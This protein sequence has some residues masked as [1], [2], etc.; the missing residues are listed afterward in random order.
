MT[1]QPLRV[2]G[3]ERLDP[4]WIQEEERQRAEQEGLQAE[5]AR[6]GT[7]APAAP[8]PATET[9]NRGAARLT[10]TIASRL[11]PVLPSSGAASTPPASA[12]QAPAAPVFTSSA[13]AAPASPTYSTGNAWVDSLRPTAE[14]YGQQLGGIPPEI[15]IAMNASESNWGAAPTLF[16]IK[17]KSP[18][19]KS[20]S[21]ATWESVN[22][23]RVDINDEFA[24]YDSPD[25]AYQHFISFL[26]DNP[27]YADAVKKAKAGDY[28]GFV[29]GLN[30]AGYATDPKWADL[31]LG[32]ASDI[33][34][35]RVPR[36]DA[37]A[38]GATSTAE[39]EKVNRRG[40]MARLGVAA[41][42]R[43]QEDQQQEQPRG[44]LGTIKRAAGDV[45]KAATVEIPG[46]KQVQDVVGRIGE[47]NPVG[48]L[49]ATDPLK[50]LDV[51]LVPLNLAGKGLEAAGVS[52]PLDNVSVR[53]AVVSNLP[54]GEFLNVLRGLGQDAQREIAESAIPVKVWEAALMAVPE[55]AKVPGGIRAARSL[56]QNI[57]TEE[58]ALAV[59]P[60][61]RRA[62]TEVPAF[63]PEARQVAETAGRVITPA[64]VG[65]TA[66][67]GIQL[68]GG[69]AETLPRVERAAWDV[70]DLGDTGIKAA[71]SAKQEAT[72]EPGALFGDTGSIQRKVV[73]AINPSV[74]MPREVHVAN[75]AR[76]AV[77]STT[78][79]QFAND[80]IRAY[81]ALEAAFNAN[82]PAYLGDA[83]RPLANTWVDFA[84]NPRL[85]EAGDALQAAKENL[86]AVQNRIISTVRSE[87]GVDVK[88]FQGADPDSVYIP[89]LQSRESMDK[90]VESTTRSLSSR[91]SVTKERAYDSLSDRMARDPKF[92]PELDAAVLADTHSSSLAQMAANN[93]FKAGVGGM[94]KVD[95]INELHPGLRGALIDARDMVT[96]LRGRIQ[97]AMRQAGENAAAGNLAESQ[98]NAINRR[99]EPLEARVESLGEEYGPEMAGLTSRIREMRTQLAQ[100]GSRSAFKASR[101]IG[102][103]ARAQ[104]LRRELD[105]AQRQV[106]YLAKAY[107]TAS[108]GDYALNPSTYRYHLPEVDQAIRSVGKTG[109]D[110]AF[111]DGLISTANTSRAAALGPDFSP[112]TIQG[113]LGFFSHPEIAFTDAGGLVK[114][115][116]QSPEA[117]RNALDPDLVRRFEFASNRTLGSLSEDFV[118]NRGIEL[119]GQ[120]LKKFNDALQ[121]VVDYG[122]IKAFEHDSELLQKL[123]AVS[124][125]AADHE[126]ANFISKAIPRLNNRETGRSAQR[127]KLEGLLPTSRSF[128]VAPALVAKDFLSGIAK[129]GTGGQ[130]LGRE[131]LALVRGTTA[132]GT[133]MSISIASALAFAEANGKNPTEAVKE[134]LDPNSSR[135]ASIIVGDEGSFSL[136]GPFR[137]AFLGLFRTV[138]PLAPGGDP[139][140]DAVNSPLR[141][142][143]NTLQP[144]I[145]T[146]VDVAMNR[147]WR[148][149]VIREGDSLAQLQQVVE[150]YAKNAN[151]LAGG[152]IEGMEE[153]GIS[154]ALTQIGAGLGGVNY[155]DRSPAELRNRARAD[156]TGEMFPGRKYEDLLTSEQAQVDADPRVARAIGDA[157]NYYGS[158]EYTVNRDR[159]LQ[160]LATEQETIEG[161][162]QRGE[163]SKPLPDLMRDLKSRRFQTLQDLKDD[164]AD[165]FKKLPDR[166]H[167]ESL[168]GFYAIE[169]KN[170]DGT[171]NWDKTI[172]AREDFIASL[173]DEEQAWVN[174]FLGFQQTKKSAIE[175]EYTAYNDRREQLG[176]F[177]PDADTKAL[178]RANPDIDF[179]TWRF[180]GGVQ[181]K[182]KNPD[183]VLQ[184]KEA[185]DKALAAN[186]PGRQV[187]LDGLSR[188]INE[189]QQTLAAWQQVGARLDKYLSGAQVERY[190]E[191]VAQQ[192]YQKPFKELTDNQQSSIAAY[193]QTEVRKSS[194]ELDAWLAWFG[195]YSVIQSFAA[196]SVLREIRNTYG[197]EP[198]GNDGPIRY[199]DNAR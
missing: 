55:I 65:D 101:E 161:A 103:E 36:S 2:P 167:Q 12:A 34:G 108:T 62:I 71:L 73:G 31:I 119:P 175:Q 35:G 117:L 77:L 17:G 26:N 130:L 83:S 95:V 60:A 49:A 75:Q 184:S 18:S 147:D 82:P 19:G 109:F 89:H 134:V 58:E 37:R 100:L 145:G 59:I 42:I 152:A 90:A 27:R 190:R 162:W 116:F 160:N 153:G 97:T 16:G 1:L 87:Y 43:A 46:A 111:I 24:V 177:A 137:R 157:K 69:A 53:D 85:Y 45:A 72:L 140:R 11:A 67:L 38:L 120:P 9:I 106:D 6:R 48:P 93:T 105:E 171:M 13:Q 70:P 131:K 4:A 188:P 199:A 176:Y 193:I 25:E 168:D 10:G 123:G 133:I 88:P 91:G 196:G 179:D 125:N 92:V 94:T 78:R 114:A 195:K 127:V 44:L 8:P 148:G 40:T 32:I 74:D 104:D 80:E 110:N 122:T 33:S 158:S 170:P 128:T 76:S 189:S 30:T 3:L 52:N 164:N 129:L 113:G 68:S 84:E 198:V 112:L 102:A 126:A 98:I 20:Q 192:R 169:F 22:N 121:R 144:A 86:R 29:R 159:R 146:T 186:L 149:N 141:Y 165:F 81:R 47:A 166:A 139:A 194:P 132:M 54:G 156:V 63:S 79:S 138:E 143:R 173:P 57:R 154:G 23:Q 163:L 56:L 142:A 115:A 99:M 66:P 14:K 50:V 180:Y 155:F 118:G 124:Q 151:I 150:E 15:L 39:A 7:I 136:G 61:I 178:D 41:R 182:E 191:Q 174:D 64:R 107:R 183:P 187:K 21:F 96:S 51:P 197:R 5:L 135:F 28:E 181:D 185:V 172:P